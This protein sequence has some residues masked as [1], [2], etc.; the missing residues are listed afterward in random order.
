MITNLFH[1]CTGLFKR[2]KCSNS[3][4]SLPFDGASVD[5]PLNVVKRAPEVTAKDCLEVVFVPDRLLTPFVRFDFGSKVGTKCN[6][7]L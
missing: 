7:M 4:Y 1:F 3:N 5:G 2:N 6:Q